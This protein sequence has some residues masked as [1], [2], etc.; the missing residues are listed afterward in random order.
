[1]IDVIT[2]N[3]P[4][5]EG[6]LSKRIKYKSIE[7]EVKCG[8]YYLRIW[9]KNNEKHE[10]IEILEKEEPNYYENLKGSF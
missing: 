4:L 8:K 1:M 3:I 10:T 5:Y 7:K 9:V 2:D 6:R